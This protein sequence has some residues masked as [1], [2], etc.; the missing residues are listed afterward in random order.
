[1]AKGMHVRPDLRTR[2]DPLDTPVQL[3]I[4][5]PWHYREQLSQKAI[6]ERMSL[7]RLI[8]TALVR[9]YPP[10]RRSDTQR[11]DASPFEQ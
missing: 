9:A 6:D 3:N 1:M 11:A 8:V 5:I 10:E 2:L 4:K 7:T